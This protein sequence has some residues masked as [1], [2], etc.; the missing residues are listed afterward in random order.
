MRTSKIRLTALSLSLLAAF[1]AA[2]QTTDS[3]RIKLL[4]QKFNQSLSVIDQLQKR[5]AELEQRQGSAAAAV[6]VPGVATRVETLERAVSDLATS[7]SKA[8]TDTGLPLHGF[9][10]VG[11]AS[12]SGSRPAYDN[13][14]FKLGTFDIYLTPQLGDR[15]KGLVELAFEYGNDGGL[16]TDLE[17]LQLG[18]VFSDNLTLWGGRFHT[19]LGYWNTAFHH[20]AQIQTSVT[21]PRMVAF[22]DQGGIMPSHTVG[23]WVNAKVDTAMGRWRLD[24]F[25][26]NSDS[27]RDGTL[28]Y[29]ASGYNNSTP[30]YGFNIGLRPASMPGL[31]LGLHGLSEKINSYDIAT[32]LNGQIEL[33][34]LGGYAFFESDN[35]EIIGEYYG[36]NNNDTFGLAGKN[37]SSAGFIQAGYLLADRLT[38]FARYEKA[39]LSKKD[40]YF[41]LMNNGTTNFGS[42]YY[43]STIGLR[44]DVDPRS[45]MKVQYE[46]I[47]DDGNAGQ[48]VNW[49]R[50]QYSVRF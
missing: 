24:A 31:T 42:S 2:A 27:L 20:G 41:A 49:L 15:V 23:A 17:R 6:A 29:N 32:T 4:E 22:E 16:G 45:A 9:I 33:Q 47:T 1:S 50:A 44:Y 11:Y 5:I 3:D 19:P 46:Q 13:P 21:R 12:A 18:Y 10:D 14:G 8:P 40:P 34:V 35:W 28:D 43:Q 7:A 30:A 25:V 39:D 37:Q 26:G 36:F 38:G 48:T